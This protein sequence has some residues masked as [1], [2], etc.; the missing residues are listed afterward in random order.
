MLLLLS[1]RLLL[2]LWKLLIP[3]LQAGAVI[4]C[5]R[6]PRQI[7]EFLAMALAKVGGVCRLFCWY[8]PTGCGI[9]CW[10]CCWSSLLLSLLHLAPAVNSTVGLCQNSS[11]I[12]RL[13]FWCCYQ[14][15]REN[16]NRK[17]EKVNFF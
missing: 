4:S 9:N 17:K 14:Q 11:K 8:L 10:C 3:I 5:C 12:H 7:W 2:L 6:S 13:A 16:V 15:S 1:T